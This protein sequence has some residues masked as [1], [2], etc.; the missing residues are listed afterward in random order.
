MVGGVT[1]TA[2]RFGMPN[3]A[4]YFDGLTAVVTVDQSGALFNLGQSEYTICGWFSTSDISKQLQTV[5]NTIPHNGVVVDF[6]HGMYP[7]PPKLSYAIGTGAPGDWNMTQAGNKSDYSQNQWYFFAVVKNASNYGFF[8][9]AVLD[10][11]V[12]VPQSSS[13]NIPV[14]CYMGAYPLDSQFFHGSLDDF[15]IYDHAVSAAEMPWLMQ[16]SCL[17]AGWLLAEPDSGVI[18]IGS[19][20][21]ITLSFDATGLDV[22]EYNAALKIGCNDP[23]LPIK[24]IPMHIVVTPGPVLNRN[25]L[26]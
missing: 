2:D 20:V 15:R 24:K 18:P 23:F 8:I 7:P 22:G 25:Q 21:E 13:Y 4:L 17:S 14:G 6:N 9:D 12:D 1:A 19:T 11:Q 10:L 3:G 26:L 16:Q 5:F